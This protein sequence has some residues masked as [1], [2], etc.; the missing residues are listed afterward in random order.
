MSIPTTND[1]FLKSMYRA[2]ESMGLDVF[3]FK[4]Y[5]FDLY[6]K[7]QITNGKIGDLNKLGVA[8]F[9]L[10]LAA[11]TTAQP[12]Y[13]TH[14]A[15][16]IATIGGAPALLSS[17]GRWK[18]LSET[19]E[20]AILGGPSKPLKRTYVNESTGPTVNLY[21][22]GGTVNA[23]SLSL[24]DPAAP[25]GV[26]GDKAILIIDSSV[27][28]GVRTNLAWIKYHT[29]IITNIDQYMGTNAFSRRTYNPE[30]KLYGP[31]ALSAT[32][33][34]YD[35]AS[36]NNLV[37]AII[38]VAANLIDDTAGSGNLDATWSADKL[39]T[40]KDKTEQNF[41]DMTKLMSV[42][43]HGWA[44]SITLTS[45][46]TTATLITD[47][48]FY[49]PNGTAAALYRLNNG[50][51]NEYMLAVHRKNNSNTAFINSATPNIDST[52]IT[53]YSQ[54]NTL[55]QQI[56]DYFSSMVSVLDTAEVG[57]GAGKLTVTS[58]TLWV[59]KTIVLPQ[60]DVV[61][62]LNYLASRL[63]NLDQSKVISDTSTYGTDYTYSIDKIREIIASNRSQLKAEILGGADTAYDTLVE[64]QAFLTGNA[65]ITKGVLTL[66][67]KSLRADVDQEWTVA[68]KLRL[69]K[70]LG[71]S[72]DTYGTNIDFYNVYIASST[73]GVTTFV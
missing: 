2:V 8:G 24:D 27:T 46:N 63:N 39:K 72:D 68:E 19:G 5:I 51:S 33:G 37:D 41:G 54:F 70:N 18:I 23:Y 15:N 53:N 73:T 48:D 67:S 44:T 62:S 32:D 28:D 47:S 56:Q 59:A 58:E 26:N 21:P 35:E 42:S 66:L 6:V 69:Y 13:A 34:T 9:N 38:M 55:N 71:L 64:I 29:A 30:D 14:I 43:T 50:T 40:F 60:T 11:A 12:E 4:N 10:N 31:Y 7:D 20:P 25:V 65:D 3:T 1:T 57:T 61:S 16:Q 22:K 17:G 45:P 49:T 36:P 52:V